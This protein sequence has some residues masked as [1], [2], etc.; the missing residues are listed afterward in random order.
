MTT[1]GE[2][3]SDTE[4]SAKQSAQPHRSRRTEAEMSAAPASASTPLH[5]ETT[6]NENRDY[7]SLFFLKKHL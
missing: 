4:Q 1:S 6:D 5:F 2:S 3:G 7:V